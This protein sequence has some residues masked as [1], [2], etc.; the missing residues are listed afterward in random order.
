MFKWEQRVEEKRKI[1][2]ERTRERVR[3]AELG[4]GARPGYLPTH[5]VFK[6]ITKD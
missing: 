6:I 5:K 1:V 2:V 4:K 3:K